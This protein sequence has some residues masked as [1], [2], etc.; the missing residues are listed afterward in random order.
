MKLIIGASYLKA[1]L[2][3][4]FGGNPRAGICPTK[5]GPVLI[6]SDPKSGAPFGY[7]THD[8][9]VE[10]IY[11]YTGEG[12]RGDQQLVRGN[13]ALLERSELLLFSRIDRQSWC[14]VGSV[15]LAKPEFETAAAKDEKGLPRQVFVFRFAPLAADFSLIRN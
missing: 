8:Q 11:R 3:A 2:H 13:K 6:F 7:D 10:G 9:V 1:E 4:A 14:F 12:R 15:K 5:S